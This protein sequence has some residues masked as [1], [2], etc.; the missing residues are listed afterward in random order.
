ML[1]LPP[2]A[3]N[4]SPQNGTPGHCMVAQVWDERGNNLAE[5]EPTADP[6]YATMIARL[7]A[8]S[9]LLVTLVEQLIS[10]AP[11]SGRDHDFN[12]DQEMW[13]RTCAAAQELVAELRSTP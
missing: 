6:A 4:F 3:F 2:F 10:S 7:F 8:K 13:D 1:E 11:S 9:P 12:F 5:V